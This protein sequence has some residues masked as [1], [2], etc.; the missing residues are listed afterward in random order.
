MNFKKTL[1][2][3]YSLPVTLTQPKNMVDATKVFYF[4]LLNF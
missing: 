3:A 1:L 2:V 4:Q